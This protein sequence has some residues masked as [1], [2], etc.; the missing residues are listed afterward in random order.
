MKNKRKRKINQNKRR[1]D[2][3]SH[4]EKHEKMVKLMENDTTLHPALVVQDEFFD[5]YKEFLNGPDMRD[6]D[7]QGLIDAGVQLA[8]SDTKENGFTRY[9][10]MYDTARVGAYMLGLDF[11]CKLDKSWPKD[12]ASEALNDYVR[13]CFVSIMRELTNYTPGD[14]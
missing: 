3:I 12:K 2:E 1:F 10:Y 7:L 4:E 11:H 6:H 13:Y 14:Q 5:S 9:E 8:V